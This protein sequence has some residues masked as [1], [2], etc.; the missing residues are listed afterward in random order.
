MRPRAA[1]TAAAAGVGTNPAY[2]LDEAEG[3]KGRAASGGAGSGGGGIYQV[4]VL[5]LGSS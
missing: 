4:D 3:S 2:R 5:H 1:S